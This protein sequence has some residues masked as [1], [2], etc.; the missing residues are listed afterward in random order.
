MKL[1]AVL[2]HASLSGPDKSKLDFDYSERMLDLGTDLS[3][4]GFELIGNSVFGR[5]SQSTSFAK[6]HGNVPG[7]HA[8]G[9]KPYRPDHNTG[10]Q[11]A[12]LWYNLSIHQ[13]AAWPYPASPLQLS[14]ARSRPTNAD[15]TLCFP[16]RISL[17]KPAQ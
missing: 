14:M 7:G 12:H 10:R 16:S 13:H 2:S 11:N 17:A 5:L 3:I 1:S 4:Q 6:S 8:S 15:T 9:R